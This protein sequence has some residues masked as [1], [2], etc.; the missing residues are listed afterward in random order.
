M[1]PVMI[2]TT[3][4]QLAKLSKTIYDM[5]EQDGG[6]TDEQKERV[7]QAVQDANDAWENA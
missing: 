3:A 4:I 2:A 5:I 1:D 6:L 7:K